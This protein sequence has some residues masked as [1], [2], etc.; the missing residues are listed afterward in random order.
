MTNRKQARF[1]TLALLAASLALPSMAQLH[2]PNGLAVD[3]HGRLWIANNG[4][5]SVLKVNASTGQ[6]LQRITDG[7]DGPSRLAFDS[8]GNLY[9]ANTTGNTITEYDT[10]YTNSGAGPGT[11][12][13]TIS[14]SFIQGPLG[15]AVDAYGDVYIANG[16][17][18]NVVAVN[19]DGGLVETI[20]A[21]K[22]GFSFTSP[23]ALAIY[24]QDLY[25]GLG[26]Q[27]GEN[28]VISYNVGEFLTG[29]PK[30]QVVFTNSVNTG[31]TG[32]AF[33]SAGN[34]YVSDLFSGTWAQY[35]PSGVFQFAVT[36]GFPEGIAWDPATGYI[37]VTNSSANNIG[38]FTTSGTPV[39]TLF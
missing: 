24:G 26:P 31:P 25:L 15:V 28:A 12:I 5:N 1:F 10:A 14:G 19:I 17:A 30:E 33:D 35:N 2:N 23:G 7:L 9:V 39:T 16:G 20:T 29:D 13:R 32:I 22:S 37:Y 34:V 36:S 21:D 8:L 11:L 27:P 4:A 18:N 3:S 6:V 38:V